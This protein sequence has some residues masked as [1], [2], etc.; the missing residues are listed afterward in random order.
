M[1]LG[2]AHSDGPTDLL[3]DC[4]LFSSTVVGGWFSRSHV[5]VETRPGVDPALAMLIAHLCT[6]EYSVAE[7]KRDLSVRIS[8]ALLWCSYSLVRS[9]LHLILQTLGFTMDFKMY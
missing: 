1:V 5:I 2:D 6:T 9:T 8:L 7:I 4:P 3:I